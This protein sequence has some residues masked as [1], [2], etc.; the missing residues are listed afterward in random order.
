MAATN[1][2]TKQPLCRRHAKQAL[3]FHKPLASK[4]WPYV[5]KKLTHAI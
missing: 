3:S 4:T 5:G 1:S 2:K